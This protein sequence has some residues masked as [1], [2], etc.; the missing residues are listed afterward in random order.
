MLPAPTTPAAKR[1]AALALAVAAALLLITT[2]RHYGY[3]VL[4]VQH[5]GVGSKGLGG[6]ALLAQ[7]WVIYALIPSR[8]VLPVVLFVTWQELQVVLCSAAYIHAPWPVPQGKSICSAMA[9]FDIG[10]ASIIAT[11]FLARWLAVRLYRPRP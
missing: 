8:L 1:A 3:D 7:A 9:G 4:P 6:A 2:V 5:R 11:A 10:A